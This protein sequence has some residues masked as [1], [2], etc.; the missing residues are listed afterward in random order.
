M[1]MS[2]V[3]KLKSRIT[4]LFGTRKKSLVAAQQAGQ[5]SV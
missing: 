5:E 4:G 1:S 3:D 2:I